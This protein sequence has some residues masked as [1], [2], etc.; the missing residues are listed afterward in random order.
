MRTH[1]KYIENERNT[2]SFFSEKQTQQNPKILI[3]EKNPAD[4]AIVRNLL[5][6]LSYQNT[7]IARS[8]KE[9]IEIFSASRFDMV[10]I[11]AGLFDAN[12]I[13]L[14]TQMRSLH[15]DEHIPIISYMD[16]EQKIELQ[17]FDKVFHDFIFMLLVFYARFNDFQRAVQRCAHF[18][19]DIS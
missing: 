4:A 19:N 3:V 8:A 15:S 9:A 12:E 14:C 17:N 6:S 13:N 10:I 5:E 1:Q 11:G 18:D 16:F 2:V 7:A